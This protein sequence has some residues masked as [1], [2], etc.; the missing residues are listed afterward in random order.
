MVLCI[1]PYKGYT[2][3]RDILKNVNLFFPAGKRS[4][5][6]GTSGCGK[7]TIIRL[8]FGLYRPDTGRILIDGHDMAESDIRSVRA[9]MGVVPQET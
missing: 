1:F 7:S 4:A 9:Y 8:I 3:E 6:V 2:K 5:I